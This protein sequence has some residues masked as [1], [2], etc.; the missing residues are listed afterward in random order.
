MNT[1][2]VLAIIFIS[3]MA[4][5]LGRKASKSKQGFFV[6]RAIPVAPVIRRPLILP[7]RPL[8]RRFIR[9][10]IGAVHMEFRICSNICS[11]RHAQYNDIAP[12]VN[13]LG[14]LVCVTNEDGGRKIIPEL[15]YCN[16]NGKCWQKS[17]LRPCYARRRK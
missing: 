2:K 8:I 3:C 5:V 7:Q 15:D 9:S 16:L 12:R 4:I 10:P 1:I 14:N 11:E 17:P 13:R 6:R